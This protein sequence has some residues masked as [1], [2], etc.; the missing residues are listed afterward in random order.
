MTAR[1]LIARAIPP[2]AMPS[3]SWIHLLER[4]LLVGRQLWIIVISGFFEPVFYLF[5][6]GVGIGPLVG[7]VAGPGGQSIPY[8]L[9]VAPAL[10]AASAMNG[11]VFESTNIFF[12]M[13]YGRIYEAVLAT[14]LSPGDVAVGEIAYSLMRGSVYAF[15]FLGVMRVAGYMPSPWGWLALPAALLIGFAFGAA[16]MAAVAHMRSWQDLDL[17]TMVTLPLFLFSSTFFPITD[18]PGWLQPVVQISPLYHGIEIVRALTLGV[19][20]WSLV[21]HVAFLVGM[22]LLGLLIAGRRIASLMLQ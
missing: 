1:T 10:L 12:K 5:S 7:E 11:A 14:P 3:R 4:N 2:I 17:V 18:Y 21:G 13:K 19:F 22:G 15:G 20:D 6:I 9:F 16:G 8:A